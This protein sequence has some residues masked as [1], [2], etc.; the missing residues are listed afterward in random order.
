VARAPLNGSR[1]ASR[2]LDAEPLHHPEAR[3]PTSARD[4]QLS[5]TVSIRVAVRPDGSVEEAVVVTS[6]L[7]RQLLPFTCD[8]A[9]R[10]QRDLE[11]TLGID[12]S[13]GIE[14][15]AL[16]AARQWTFRRVDGIGSAVSEV[17]TIEFRFKAPRK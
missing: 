12:P 15:S 16:A 9:D 14:A 17:V 5:G 7:K 10:A 2:R 4:T 3:Y 1:N 13:F 6:C 8:E 11:R